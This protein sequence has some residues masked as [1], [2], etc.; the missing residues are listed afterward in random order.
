MSR[1]SIVC[2][3]QRTIESDLIHRHINREWAV[4]ECLSPIDQK[5]DCV[6]PCIHT[7]ECA[8]LYEIANV[9]CKIVRR[10]NRMK[11]NLFIRFFH[12]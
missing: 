12:V 6:K 9:L 10:T 5:T 7:S 1:V 8:Q 2:K 3:Y 4:C 11:F